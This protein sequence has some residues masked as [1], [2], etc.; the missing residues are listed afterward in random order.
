MPL[1]VIR[2]VKVVPCILEGKKNLELC[3]E[4]VICRG[5]GFTMMILSPI[6]FLI[7]SHD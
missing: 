4:R 3:T 2:F 5:N 7:V 1:K 6:L